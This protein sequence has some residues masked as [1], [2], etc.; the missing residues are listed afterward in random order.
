MERNLI[1]C[2][3]WVLIAYLREENGK[4]YIE[5]DDWEGERIQFVG[6][7]RRALRKQMYEWLKEHEQRGEVPALVRKGFDIS[8]KGEE[9]LL[10]VREAMVTYHV[11][12]SE[13]RSSVLEK[14]LIPSF[15]QSVDVFHASV[16][17][18]QLK[19]NWIPG[20]VRRSEALYLFPVMSID[21]L[22]ILGYREQQDLF[23]VNLPDTKGWMG[24]QMYGGYCMSE[25]P[26]TDN[27]RL[28]FIEEEI[29]KMYWGC[30]CS[31]EDYIRYDRKT[32]KKDRRVDGLDEILFFGS[33]PPE[34]IE[35]IGTYYGE[36]FVP[37]SAF[38]K[39]VKEEYKQTWRHI[40][41]VK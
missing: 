21:E 41:G 33:I 17:L 1:H 22:L 15:A 18:D 30:S 6:D 20:W 2:G 40:I 16:L 11:T 14:G 29:A 32:M 13:H 23:A 8:Y 38:E 10:N 24:S 36:E 5:A 37:S 26:I 34:N 4:L 39:Y 31:L 9:I 3:D 27:E 25:E 19:P 12:S 28:Q 7:S 35:L